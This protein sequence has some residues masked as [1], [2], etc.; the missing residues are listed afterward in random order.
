MNKQMLEALRD[1]WQFAALYTGKGSDGGFSPDVLDEN[2]EPCPQKIAD[3]AEAAMIP[4]G[5]T[6]TTTRDLTDQ[7]EDGNDRLTKAGSV[8]RVSV[9][10]GRA[11]VLFP[12]GGWHVFGPEDDPADYEVGGNYSAEL[13][14]YAVTL[15]RSD[16][17]GRMV[18]Q[19]ETE[20]V[21]ENAP[22][23][24]TPIRIYVNDGR[25]YECDGEG[26]E[27]YGE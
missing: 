26:R 22:N 14:G 23:G 1:A 20:E 12:G 3:K 21:E 16:I 24:L 18:V 8:G 6:L 27:S 7:D 9:I 2:G 10:D 15:H 5:A 13:E 11:H 19:V 4:H 17:D 25:V